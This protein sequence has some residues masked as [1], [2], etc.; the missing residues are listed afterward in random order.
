M[1][2]HSSN[3]GVFVKIIFLLFDSFKAFANSSFRLGKGGSV[4]MAVG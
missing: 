4:A 1:V 2:L 3:F